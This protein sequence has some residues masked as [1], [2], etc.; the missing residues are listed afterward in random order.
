MLLGAVM[1][2]VFGIGLLA[3]AEAR[4]G[5]G[6]ALIVIGAVLVGA[7][8]ALLASHGHSGRDAE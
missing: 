5:A 4:N 8:V 3:G 1:A 6:E 7:W 2:F